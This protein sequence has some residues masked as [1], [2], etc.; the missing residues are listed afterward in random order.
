MNYRSAPGRDVAG[1]PGRVTISDVALKAGVSKATVS[2]FLNRREELLTPEIAVRVERAIADLGYTPSPM[3]QALK[4]GRSRLI[5][6][7]VADVTN[8][9]SVA[10]LRGA[11][12]ACQNGGYLLMLFNLGN[13]SERERE[14]I[15][16]LSSYQVEGLIL[17]T[18]GRD[19]GAVAQ[20]VRHGKPVVLVDRRHSGMQTDFVSID[21]AGAV[22]LAAA[23]L[24]SAG[25][26]ELL[27]V[28]EPL[29]GVSSRI[30]REAAFRAFVAD[31]GGEVAGRT[32][33]STADDI[34]ALEAELRALRGR[35]GARAPAVLA[36]NA[37]ISLR[38]A[39]AVAR[40][41][42]HFGVDLG[43]VGFDET[44]W[45]PL[46]G[47]GLTTIAQPTDDLGRLAVS[48]LLERLNGLVLPPRQILLAGRLIERGSSRTVESVLG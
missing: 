17:N 31:H 48:C 12:R 20:A 40:L 47:P 8:P 19:E 32:F 41:G 43:L 37:V 29:S 18:L 38:V 1:L 24:K 36:S 9:F 6:L 11:E 30:E 42:W 2:R 22:H 28:S 33:E 26:R 25:Y 23:H 3:A 35:A 34:P 5:G 27:F 16:A 4:R 45:A 14:A 21:N 46:I 10:V 44:E 15:E 13:E 39:A 7:V